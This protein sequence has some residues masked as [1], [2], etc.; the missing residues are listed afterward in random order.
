MSKP[1]LKCGICRSGEF[2]FAISLFRLQDHGPVGGW[3][4]HRVP[5]ARTRKP[6]THGRGIDVETDDVFEFLGEFLGCAAIRDDRRKSMA[7]CSG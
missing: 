3:L 2:V 4:L 6:R 5:I 7:V 1:G